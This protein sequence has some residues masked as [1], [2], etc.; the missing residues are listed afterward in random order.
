MNPKNKSILYLEDDIL[1]AQSF[2]RLLTLFF[3]K[4]VHCTN[5]CE[6]LEKYHKNKFDIIITDINMPMMN[7]IEFARNIRNIDKYI[8]IFLHSSFQ[9]K[10][11]DLKGINITAYLKK[12]LSSKD[13]MNF[14]KQCEI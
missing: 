5:G 7:G 6:G 12:P 4:V 13:F 1:I 10:D 2:H 9:E 11:V 8:P 14:I 3:K